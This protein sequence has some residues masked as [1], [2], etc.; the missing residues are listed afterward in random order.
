M[1][2]L[3]GDSVLGVLNFESRKAG[4]FQKTDVSLLSFLAS[5]LAIA[6]KMVE[7]DQRAR[8]WQD[9]VAALHN[10]SRL[11]GGDPVRAVVEDVELGRVRDAE[12][13]VHR[14]VGVAHLL[15][16]ED[17]EVGRVVLAEQAVAIDE[18]AA[19]RLPGRR[20]RYRQR[21]RPCFESA[22]PLLALLFPGTT[23]R[24]DKSAGEL[25]LLLLTRKIDQ[26]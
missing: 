19:A 21:V 26:L 7:L 8:R 15:A 12:V 16:R 2:I 3:S 14:V 20:L 25:M 17:L 23:R 9:R 1:P 6:L 22:I 5:Q 10:L 4:Y 24:T 13:E 18:Q 11:G